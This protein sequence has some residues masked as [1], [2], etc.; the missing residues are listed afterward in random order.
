MLACLFAVAWNAT[1]GATV[2]AL[3]SFDAKSVPQD[4]LDFAQAYAMKRQGRHLNS[5]EMEAMQARI[6]PLQARMMHAQGMV[7]RHLESKDE[8][9]KE[10][11]KAIHD[12]LAKYLEE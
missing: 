6:L 3:S 8:L 11:E 12:M 7:L 2:H 5:E 1:T 10:C 4:V 9:S